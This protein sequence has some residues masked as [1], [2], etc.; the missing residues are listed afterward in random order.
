MNPVRTWSFGRPL[1]AIVA[2]AALGA[3]V[4][5]AA[6]SK[7][8]HK[9]DPVQLTVQ[10]NKPGRAIP[11]GFVGF[12]TEYWAIPKYAGEDPKALDP[13]FEQLIR[14]LAPGARPVLRLGGDSTDWTWWPVHGIRKPPGIRYTLTPQWMQITKA[15]TT[16]TNARLL[17]GINLEADNRRL[18][19]GE[20]RALIQNLGRGST[21]ALEIGN[22]PELYGA[23]GWYRTKR[24]HEV[25]G[26]PASYDPRA[27][28]NDFSTFAKHMPQIP[29]A[30]P[31]TGSPV[32]LDHLNQFLTAEPRVR[33]ATVHAY[34]LKRCERTTH[35]TAAQLLSNASSTGLAQ[36]VAPLANT[37]HRHHV[38]L[39]IDEINAISCGGERGVSDTYAAALWSLDAMFALANAG[40][41]GVNIHTPPRSIN[42]MIT[43]R[44]DHGVWSA[45][46]APVYYGLL[47]FADA[48][49]PGSRLVRITAKTAPGL[50]TWATVDEKQTLRVVLINKSTSATRHARIRAPARASAGIVQLLRA[51]GLAARNGVTLGG[52]SFATETTTGTLVGPST[53]AAITSSKRSFTVTVPPASAALLTIPRS[54]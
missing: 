44:D 15:L 46:V 47:M 43:F 11:S 19:A 33:V 25:R 30:G 41:D 28:T 18:A 5:F 20:A 12:S 40:V 23:F 32:Y 34:P 27:F 3:G 49:P 48:T 52:Q 45:H 31:S 13:V 39:R 6:V 53:A 38:P 24:G 17:L 2:V 22:E 37:A 21:A 14:N 9:G 10:T 50:S 7:Q 35:V 36:R 51:P 29:L 4:A 26:R 16:A 42:Q 8:G 1:I 54:S